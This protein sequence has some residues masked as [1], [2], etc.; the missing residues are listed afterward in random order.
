MSGVG[1]YEPARSRVHRTCPPPVAPSASVMSPRAPGLITKMGAFGT[2]AAHHHDEVAVEH[3]RGRGD[4]RAAAEPPELLARARVVAADELRRV[5]DQLGLARA[6]AGVD[7]R[8]GPGRELFARGA[9][10][11]GAV[12]ETQRDQ[13]GVLLLVA[14]HDDEVLVQDRRAGGAPLVVRR[15]V[16]ADVE[17]PEVPLPL[18][19][20]A[21]VVGVETLR[22]EERDHVA[23][24][25]GRRR[26][27]V[28]GLDV[29]LL[30]RH[31]L[32]GRALPQDLAAPL[33]QAQDVPAMDGPVLGRRALAVEAGLER[34][35]RG[36]TRWPWS[37]RAARP[38]RRGSSG[39][40][41][42]CAPS[43]AMPAPAAPKVSGR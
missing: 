42:G 9:P 38:R 24:V 7:V 10:G 3:R 34:S 23:A 43:T 6:G 19:R 5:G 40:A 33:V 25:R 8:R 37:R 28:G 26:V 27:G 29:P 31:S 21:E 36:A 41:R 11:D 32:V 1:M 20:A 22:A 4:V 17:A 30:A 2:P 14:L 35:R 39:P 15:I 16:G 13:E 18:Q 12:L